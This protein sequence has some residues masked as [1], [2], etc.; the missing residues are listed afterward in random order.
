MDALAGGG[1]FG[2][3][4]GRSLALVH[5]IVMGGLFDYTL[6]AGYLGWKWRRVGTIQNEINELKKQEKPVAV[7]PEGTPVPAPP[8][9][10]QTKIQQL[11]RFQGFLPSMM[12]AAIVCIVSK[13]IESD[14]ALDYQTR[15]IDLLNICEEKIE[16]SS[17]I[18]M[19]VLNHHGSTHKRRYSSVPGSPS[20]VVN[21]Y[22]S[23]DNS[24]N[25]WTFAS[26][27]TSSPEPPL[28]KNRAQKQQMRLTPVNR[29]SISV[30]SSLNNH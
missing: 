15:L 20:S 10:L 30:L 21:A 25:S 28:K 11:L 2:I 1:E 4:E 3:F 19:D 7:T 29:V 18:I 22:F 26:S 13:E 17:K 14:N 23:S 5:P 9:T 27:I 16:G 12:V 6:Y 8:S 24:K